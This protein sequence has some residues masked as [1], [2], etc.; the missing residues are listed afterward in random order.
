MQESQPKSKSNQNVL[1]N[2]NDQRQVKDSQTNDSP[3]QLMQAE[4][5]SHK[6]EKDSKIQDIQK[7]KSVSTSAEFQK[8]SSQDPFEKN[9]LKSGVGKTKVK[10]QD[11]RQA[12]IGVQEADYKTSQIFESKKL[13]SKDEGEK[14]V[15]AEEID[16]QICGKTQADTKEK[17]GANKQMPH[18]DF[19]FVSSKDKDAKR[20]AQYDENKR[21]Q[22]QARK[23]WRQSL[24]EFVGFKV[25]LLTR[26]LC[27]IFSLGLVSSQMAHHRS[28]LLNKDRIILTP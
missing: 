18:Q 24:L 21:P 5:Q 7:E 27:E 20:K 12:Q 28:N 25:Y 3:R 22:A 4:S 19:K 9:P 1:E 8:K 23:S 15:D 11:T 10:N 13:G 26:C 16:K 2:P 14:V 17:E 6:N